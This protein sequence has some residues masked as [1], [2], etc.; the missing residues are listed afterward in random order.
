VTDASIVG[1]GEAEALPDFLAE[2]EGN[3]QDESEEEPH[4]AAAE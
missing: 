4:A 1:D 3:G 2:D